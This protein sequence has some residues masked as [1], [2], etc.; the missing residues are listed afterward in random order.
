MHSLTVLMPSEEQN[1]LVPV[2]YVDSPY[3]TKPVLCTDFCCTLDR[4]LR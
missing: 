1:T 2:S 4:V 3:T